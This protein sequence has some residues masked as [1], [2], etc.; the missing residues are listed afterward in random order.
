MLSLASFLFFVQRHSNRRKV[1]KNEFFTRK[2][3]KQLWKKFLARDVRFLFCFCCHENRNKRK[4][5]KKENRYLAERKE[6]RE[7]RRDFSMLI[8]H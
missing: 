8:A 7:K 1:K 3:K 2:R 5:K 6:K 4:K